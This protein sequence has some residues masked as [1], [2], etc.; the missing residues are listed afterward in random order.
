MK[1]NRT[2]NLVAD[3]IAP[4]AIVT[5]TVA[6]FFVF[7]PEVPGTLFWTNMVY[8]SFLEILLLAYI[9]R[10]PAHGSTV[11]LKW[12]CGIYS[13][14]YISISLI[15][16]LFFSLVLSRWC[17]IK[18][19]FAVIAVLTVL[20]I[21][22][23][24]LSLKVDNINETSIATLSDNRRQTDRINNHADMLMQQFRLMVTAHPELGVAS[25]P[26][27]ALCRGLSTLSPAVMADPTAAKRVNNICSEL[28]DK[29]SEPA[30]DT[31]ARSLKD[32]AERSLITLNQLKK[33]VRK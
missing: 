1:N 14:V 4:L 26:V 30:S 11:A 29:L 13:V 10:L 5:V 31:L 7:Q 9:V 27:T 19:Y 16:L 15:W 20:W 22:A 21:L 28:D 32:F 24:T 2:I 3:V 17:P 8:V 25:Q 6:L 18:L 23:C 12:M 33:S